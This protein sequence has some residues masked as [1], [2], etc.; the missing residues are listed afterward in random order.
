[1]PFLSSRLQSSSPYL[2]CRVRLETHEATHR[3]HTH[4]TIQVYTHTH[5]H[6]HTRTHTHKHTHTR[7][8]KRTETQTLVGKFAD[9]GPFFFDVLLHFDLLDLG[10]LVFFFEKHYQIK[11]S[12]DIRG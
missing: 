6:T 11:L 2:L 9:F 1:M 10:L 3:T 4:S 8:C 5:T 12:I 7:A